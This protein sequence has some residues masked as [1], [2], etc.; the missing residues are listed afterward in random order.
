VSVVS[1][2][3]KMASRTKQ[4]VV[5]GIWDGAEWEKKRELHKLP[6]TCICCSPCYITLAPSHR[7]LTWFLGTPE[8]LEE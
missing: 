3:E 8:F 2:L 4:A 1:G 5:A 6:D 7:F